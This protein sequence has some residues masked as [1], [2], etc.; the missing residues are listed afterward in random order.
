MRLLFL[1]GQVPTDRDPRQI[2]YDR[3]EDNCDMWTQ[4]GAEIAK[5]GYGE[6]WYWGGNR[7][8]KYRDNFV[9]RW[10]PSLNDKKDD[11]QPDV[12]IA[13]GGFPEYDAVMQRHPKAFK[14]YYGAGKRYFPQ[15]RFKSYNLIITDSERQLGE[16]KNKFP[17]IKSTLFVKP[18]ADN[19]FKP[20]SGDKECDVIFVGN[21]HAA[22]IKGHDFILKNVPKSLKMIQAGI[23]SKKLRRSFPHVSF[24][25]WI[26][27]RQIP[28][29]YAKSKVAVVCCKGIDSCPRVIPEALAC[30]CPLLVL[31]SVRFWHDKYINEK[32][33]KICTKESFVSDLQDMVDRYTD[34]VPYAYYN[35]NLSLKIAAQQLREHII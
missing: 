19:I 16:V 2:M 31:D 18:A 29:L 12:I 4:L 15:S 24:T 11:F 35:D 8:V 14:I 26:P 23:V 10:K 28:E 9:E 5:D 20:I 21:E 17:N 6:V 30:D 25:R 32:T 1:R 27:R 34:F 13:R 33:G 22:G 3:L 7:C